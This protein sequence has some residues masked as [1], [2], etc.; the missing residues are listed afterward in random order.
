M[1]LPDPG[2]EQGSPALQGDVK[3]GMINSN[4]DTTDVNW[5]YSLQI[6]CRV[7]LLTYNPKEGRGSGV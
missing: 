2:I 6:S 7:A 1:G 3:E 4:A 5:N